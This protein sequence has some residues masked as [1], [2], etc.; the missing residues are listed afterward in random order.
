MLIW[1]NGS[2]SM[3]KKVLEGSG[4]AILIQNSSG[5]RTKDSQRRHFGFA[6]CASLTLRVFQQTARAEERTIRTSSRKM[7][8]LEE[9]ATWRTGMLRL[10]AVAFALALAS[11]AQTMPLAPLQ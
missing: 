5:R 11:S 3:L 6:Y 2:S 9:R 10:V 4:C 7:A 1:I 8:F